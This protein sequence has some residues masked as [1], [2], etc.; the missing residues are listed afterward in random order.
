MAALAL[1]LDGHHVV[2]TTSGEGRRLDG[3]TDTNQLVNELLRLLIGVAGGVA[4]VV[5]TS[6]L[7]VNDPIT[8]SS[9]PV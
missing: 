7:D 4:V 1:L 9:S 8:P 3:L 2:A 5:G 6:A